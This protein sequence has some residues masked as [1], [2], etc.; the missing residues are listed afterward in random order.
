MNSTIVIVIVVVVPVII[1]IPYALRQGVGHHRP[2]TSF[3]SI[4]IEKYLKIIIF[5]GIALASIASVTGIIILIRF[6]FIRKR[7]TLIYQE[8]RLLIVIMTSNIGCIC[9]NICQLFLYKAYLG[10]DLRYGLIKNDYTAMNQV[11]FFDQLSK[12]ILILHHYT[13]FIILVCMR[14]AR[15]LA[16][17]L[18]LIFFSSLIQRT[19]INF[20]GLHRLSPYKYFRAL[21]TIFTTSNIVRITGNT[22]ISIEL[23]QRAN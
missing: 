2:L 15:T 23:S 11:Y 22:D 18:I 7:S 5:L 21:S 17:S 10:E 13:S 12:T 3:F 9:Y 4:S 1:S 20:Y 19:L 16:F 6:F 8:L 14:Y